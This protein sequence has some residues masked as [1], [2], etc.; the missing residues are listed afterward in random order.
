MSPTP[1][2]F[3]SLSYQYDV[4]RATY[5]ND[6]I[7]FCRDCIDWGVAG[8]LGR[9]QVGALRLLDEGF[10]SATRAP[11]SV[12]KTTIAAMAILHFALTRDAI[13]GRDWKVVTTAGSWRQLDKYLW[14]EVHK[15]ARRLKW[16]KI[17]R[18][19]FTKS[20]LLQRELK[21][22]TGTA[23]AVASDRADLLEG[24]HASDLL[25]IFDEAK[26]I[27]DTSWDSAEGAMIAG[28]GDRVDALAISTPGLPIGR[29]HDI[30]RRKPG[31]EM[32]A[33][34]HVTLDDAIRA[35]RITPDRVEQL[36]RL[37]GRDSPLFRQHVLGDFA[38]DGN[39]GVV[40]IAWLE[41]AHERWK[42]W[43]EEIG[44]V[45]TLDAIGVD[46][47]R[48]GN[49]FTVLAPKSGSIIVELRK[50]QGLDTMG[51]VARTTGLID[52]FGGTAVVDVIGLGA[53]VFDRLRE[54]RR[55]SLP[56]NASA[57]ALSRDGSPLRDRSGELGFLNLRAAAWWGF[58]EQ[59]DPAYEPTLA[60]PPDDDLTGELLAPR[61][62]QQSGG[63]VQVESKDDIR[64]RLGRSTDK[65]DAVVQAC[66]VDLLGHE[67]QV[68]FT[69][70]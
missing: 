24:A 65:A 5:F 68:P 69:I 42:T 41:A 36:A 7:A 21:L 28:A 60:V 53:G 18:G 12:G 3:R 56:F 39:D 35:K 50:Y 49:D 20:E 52:A 37:W 38:D 8:G 16:E 57:S 25:Y 51:T 27:P 2:V 13:P 45:S 11:R 15:W 31:T 1:D 46:V 4:F 32:W 58:R 29:F 70:G 59:L 22:T 54:L 23:F 63:K 10:R 48:S 30:H 64:K 9:Y 17:G 44:E 62:R 55:P 43:A 14:P 67:E 33:T 61:W 26:A 19:P 66:A 6:R 47:A 34:Q 40:P